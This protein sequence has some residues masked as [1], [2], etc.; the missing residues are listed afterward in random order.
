MTQAPGLL[1]SSANA[2]SRYTWHPPP[3]DPN[4]PPPAE[5]HESPKTWAEAADTKY[6]E[7]RATREKGAA[8]QRKS[9]WAKDKKPRGQNTNRSFGSSRDAVTLCGS[10]IHSPEFSPD[11][12][13]FGSKC[14]FEHD[15]RAYLAQK[16]EDLATFDGVCPVWA[17]KGVC[18]AGWKCRFAGS[19]SK[20]RD[21]EDGRKELVLIEDAARRT[22][23]GVTAN[24]ADEAGVHN[25][26]NKPTRIQINR[27]VIKTPKADEYLAWLL[28]EWN[29]QKA[30]SASAASKE[31]EDVSDKSTSEGKTAKMM[32]QDAE[33]DVRMDQPSVDVP[34]PSDASKSS[35]GVESA[36]GGVALDAESVRAPDLSKRVEPRTRFE[37][38]SGGVALD[39]ESVRAQDLPKDVE[40]RIKVEADSSDVG[41]SSYVAKQT[42]G[43]VKN[44][45]RETSPSTSDA[46]ASAGVGGAAVKSEAPAET[47]D[48]VATRHASRAE[49]KEAAAGTKEGARSD[50]RKPRDMAIEAPFLPS[51]KRRLYY[52]P[53]TPI[54]AP[55]TTQGNL[56]FRRLCVELGAQVTWSEMA[57]SMPLL[58]GGG[59]WA[60]MKAHQSEMEPPAFEGRNTVVQGYDHSKDLRFGVQIAAAKPWMAAKATELLATQCPRLRAIDVNC[61]CPLEAVCKTGAG[62]SLLDNPSKLENMVRGMNMVSGEIPITAKVRIGVRDRHPTGEKLV[63]RLVLGGYEAVEGG[64]GACGVAAIAMHGRSKQQ[65]YTRSA[66]WSYIAECAA[67]VKRIGEERDARTDTVREADARQ[68]ANEGHVYFV[69]N[70]DCYSHEDYYAHLEAG[71]VDAVMV[72]RGA[73]VKPWIFEEVAAGQYLDKRSTERLAYMDKFARYGLETWGSDEVGV[74]TTRRFLLEYLSFAHRY[75]PV[76]LLERLPPSLNERPGAVQGRDEL[77]TLMMSDNYRD[78]IKL[79]WVSRSGGGDTGG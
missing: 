39:A 65:R 17:A 59:E 29:V 44:V 31:Q 58:Q 15:L 11:E 32:D 64:R 55:L 7:Y 6:H 35:I 10:R 74:G 76:G 79:R 71:G 21:T 62:A 78:W 20:E 61:G 57:L 3:P 4:A 45:K 42:A 36:P 41:A 12:C 67:V 28:N 75:V 27:R 47:E 25:V 30:Q 18:P 33:G 60:L 52:G 46:A 51:E 24:A 14:R 49:T 13:T 48:P 56:P 5:K 19:H 8:S 77:E 9:K 40:P 43:E 50:S 53:E 26:V 1:R 72:G 54:L 37:P 66:D 2:P 63:K 70:G 38:D 16:R 69:G 22:A 73:L 68:L 34:D 23:A